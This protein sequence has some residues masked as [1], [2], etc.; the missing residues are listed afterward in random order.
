[1]ANFIEFVA[2]M[3]IGNL[4]KGDTVRVPS[5]SSRFVDAARIIA[6]AAGLDPN[7]RR[8]NSSTFQKK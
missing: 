8:V 7:D 5:N 4:K 3:A 2:R 6:K 1:M